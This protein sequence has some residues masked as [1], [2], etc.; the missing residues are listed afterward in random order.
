MRIEHHHLHDSSGNTSKQFRNGGSVIAKKIVQRRNSAR[1]LYY[2]THDQLRQHLADF[3]ATCNL[4]HRLKILLG[5]P[6]HEFICQQWPKEPSRFIS[7]A[8]HQTPG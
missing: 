4:V 3:V 8:H 7:D 6:T 5:L 2:E 1:Q